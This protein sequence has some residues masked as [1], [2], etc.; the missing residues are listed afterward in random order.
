M[1]ARNQERER[2]DGESY[3]GNI[4]SSLL[5]QTCPLQELLFCEV[6]STPT[7]APNEF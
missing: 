5:Q 4:V 2:S 1:L 7:S 6:T 3:R